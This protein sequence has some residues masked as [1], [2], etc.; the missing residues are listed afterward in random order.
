MVWL[1]LNVK[2]VMFVLNMICF[3]DG[4]FNKLVVVWWVLVINL[5]VLLFE[6]NVLFKFEL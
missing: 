1:K 3:L 6:K 5:I 2:F 4:V